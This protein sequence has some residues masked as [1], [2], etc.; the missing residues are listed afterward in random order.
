MADS[1]ANKNDRYTASTTHPWACLLF[2]LPLL[3]VY[4]WGVLSLGGA[5]P[6]QLRN[7]AD[8]WLRWMLAKYGFAQLWMAPVLVVVIFVLLS[9][10]NWSTRPRAMISTLLGMTVES[11]LYALALW[12]LSR[13][14]LPILDQLGVTLNVTVNSISTKAMVTYVGA[15]IYE[16]VLFR[17]GAF[18][19]AVLLLRLALLPGLLAQPVG[20][21]AAALLFAAAHHAGPFGEPVVPAVFLFRT[22]AGLFFTLLYVKRG[23]G[24][25]VGA[26]AGYDVLIGAT[27]NPAG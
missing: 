1:P 5:Q 18:N 26:H 10:W 21:I 15:G 12:A 16:E 24:I 13:N 9:L 27:V 25:A 4:E 6:D 7:G 23:F 19:L 2:L 14:F 8:A 22:L 11:T 17:L 3:A 20:A